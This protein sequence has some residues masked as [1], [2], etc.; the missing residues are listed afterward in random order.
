M[1]ENEYPLL[2]SS[3]DRAI[4]FSLSF[5]VMLYSLHN[6]RKTKHTGK[7]IIHMTSCP[8]DKETGIIIVFYKV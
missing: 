1:F 5:I 2:Y 4:S 6:I 8:H 3:P 7:H